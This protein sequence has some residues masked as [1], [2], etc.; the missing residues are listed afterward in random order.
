MVFSTSVENGAAVLRIEGELDAGSLSDLRPALSG[1]S[2][3]QP[4]PPRVVVDLSALRLIDSSGVG[5]I[6][7]LY[8]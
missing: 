8:K 2:G 1:I 7:S 4:P 6:V 3:G 5:A